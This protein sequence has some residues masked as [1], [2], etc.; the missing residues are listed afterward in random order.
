MIDEDL[1]Q[2]ARR[3]GT[4]AGFLT[5]VAEVGLG[6]VGIVI[7]SEVSRLARQGVREA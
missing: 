4:R 7:S 2:S 3:A 6:R 1:G 5:L